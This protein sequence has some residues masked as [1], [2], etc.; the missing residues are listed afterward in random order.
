MNRGYIS[1][2]PVYVLSENEK[3]KLYLNYINPIQK[4]SGLGSY[5]WGNKTHYMVNSQLNRLNQRMT[6]ISLY[7]NL[8]ESMRYYLFEPMI[9]TTFNQISNKVDSILSSMKQRSAIYD[10][11]YE[12]DIR[13]E[14]ID[15][16]YLPIKIQFAPTKTLEFI[17]I[18]YIVKNYSSTLEV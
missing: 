16:N 10:Y 12:L 2:E 15:H 5:V 8:E 18:R 6:A 11:R 9:D 14:Y 17:E 4:F 3:D 7:Y 1:Q 13:P